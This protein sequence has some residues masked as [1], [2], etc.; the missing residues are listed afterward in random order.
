MTAGVLRRRR[1]GAPALR[2]I[3]A[4]ATA[5][6][7]ATLSL[8][9]GR[10]VASGSVR[11]LA[12]AVVGVVALALA[13]VK[14]KTILFVTIVASPLPLYVQGLGVS[15]T[16]GL[17]L[18]IWLA[19]ALEATRERTSMISAGKYAF[20]VSALAVAAVCALIRG[21]EARLGPDLAAFGRLFVG[22][23]LFAA[24][25]Q[26][27][28]TRDDLRRAYIAFGAAGAVIF[29]V[30][31]AQLLAPSVVIPGLVT[32]VGTVQTD[33]YGIATNLRVGG[34][35]GDYELLGEFF[36]L[37]GSV[38]A[39][40][41]VRTRSLTRLGWIVLL[42]VAM[43][44]IAGTSTR[45]GFFV[46]LLGSLVSFATARTRAVVALAVTA[47]VGSLLVVFPALHLMKSRFSSGFLFERIDQIDRGGSVFDLLGRADVWT[48]FLHQTP[49]GFD[50]LL[51]AGP[52]FDYSRFGTYPHSL[53]LTLFFTVGLVGAFAFYGL[54]ATI[55]V[56]CV[57][58]WRQ[59]REPLALLGALL[60]AL[61]VVNELKI[62]FV[63]SF[64]YEWFVWGLLGVCAATG[65]VGPEER[66]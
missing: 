54:L 59:T 43:L 32:S 48:M 40:F 55:S 62:E 30:T 12:V 56:R 65:L 41:A 61:F 37:I 24:C 3:T 50:A 27:I 39:F 66:R 15:L 49:K 57:R 22:I 23:A 45:S 16:V 28:R 9:I 11:W 26:L 52:A 17:V 13:N 47:G 5:I 38:A 34:P 29:V 33:L 18:G 4:F 64:N 6:G 53:P 10:L 51:G 31:A 2:P 63:R 42:F 8:Q 58:A 21:D 44:G 60:V 25:A 36:A 19:V 1:G 20:A 14:P 7:I 46:L 35:I